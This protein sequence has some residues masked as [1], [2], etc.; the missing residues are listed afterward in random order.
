ARAISQ[1]NIEQQDRFVRQ[2]LEEVPAS[3]ARI[4]LLGLSFKAHTDDLRGSP[5][6]HVARRLLDEGHVVVAYDPAVRPDWATAAAPGIV[7]ARQPEDVFDGAD[8]VA[9]GT[10]WPVFGALPLAE[11]RD[12]MRAPFLFDGR[13]M[14]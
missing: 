12:R 8:A 11:L 4:G 14:V 5:A 7:V 3:G 1:V 10:E 13:D 6:L 2:I 9:I